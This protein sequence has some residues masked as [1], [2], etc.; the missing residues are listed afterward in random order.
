MKQEKTVISLPATQRARFL[1]YEITVYK[2]RDTR[3][4]K[5]KRRPHG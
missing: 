5:D 1:G 3:L 2:H 4:T